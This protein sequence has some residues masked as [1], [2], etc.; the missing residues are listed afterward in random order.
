M[1]QY[2]AEEIQ[3]KYETLPDMIKDAVSSMEVKLKIEEVGKR[4]GLMLDQ[5]G[6]LVDEIGLIMLGFKKPKDFVSSITSTL[7]I[8]RDVA[9]KIAR[10]INTEVFSALRNSMI[11][12]EDT[13]ENKPQNT[14][15]VY[16]EAN[17]SIEKAGGFNLEQSDGNVNNEN[18]VSMSDFTENDTV[19]EDKDSILK[20]I[21]NP[22]PVQPTISKK[23]NLLEEDSHTDPLIDHLLSNP[24][25]TEEIKTEK[26]V[27]DTKKPTIQTIKTAGSDKYREPLE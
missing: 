13:V 25:S 12:N 27:A 20:G 1:K 14:E 22:E 26:I 7:S 10:E 19:L 23:I 5:I 4:N 8:S 9:E 3:S 17:S 2:T 11:E 18:T 15:A 24:M 21:E 6:D 16:K